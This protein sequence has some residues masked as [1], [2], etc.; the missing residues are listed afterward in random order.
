MG[1]D[2]NKP[3]AASIRHAARWTRAGKN[4]AHVGCRRNYAVRV[5]WK[6]TASFRELAAHQFM[7]TSAADVLEAAICF[8]ADQ[9]EKAAPFSFD[10]ARAT[11]EAGWRKYWSSGAA[12][13]LGNCTDERA[14]ELE[15]RIVLSQYLTAIHCAGQNT[16]AE[17]GLLCNSW[18]GKFHLEMHWW[19]SIHFTV[20]NRPEHFARSMPIYEA[21]LESSQA[22]ATPAGLSRGAMAEDDRPGWRRLA[23][24]NWPAVDLAAAASIYYAEATY[25]ARAHARHAAA[26][27]ARL[28]P[29]PRNSWPPSPRK[30][31]I[32]TCLGRGSKRCLKMPPRK[33]PLT[34]PTN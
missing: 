17:T 24:F 29:K 14:P 23:V 1:A 27:G 26:A 6:G 3:A 2:W 34:Q 7:L 22:R 10:D 8:D 21:L 28:S 12:I 33:P 4:Q 25:R 13:D 30:S 31:A 18:F 19:H 16:P 32:A 15:R 20:W 9:S 5:G 11:S